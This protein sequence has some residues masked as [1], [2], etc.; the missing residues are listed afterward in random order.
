[1]GYN[2]V[3]SV[4]ASNDIDGIVSY[5]LSEL[6]NY[7]AA[8]NFLDDMEKVYTNIEENPYMYACCDDIRLRDKGYRRV[9][10]KNY[11]VIYLIDEDMKIVNVIR[12]IYGGRNYANFL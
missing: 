10:I 3:V 5:M 12:V 9:V 7:S 4:N 2:L 6:K 8:V 11:L 1:M